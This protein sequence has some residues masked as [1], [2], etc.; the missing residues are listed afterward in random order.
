MTRR[1]DGC[2]ERKECPTLIKAW[3]RSDDDIEYN[4]CE[5]CDQN[6]V[7]PKFIQLRGEGTVTVTGES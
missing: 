4:Y 2:G 6:I 5:Q 7:L 1:C 3:F